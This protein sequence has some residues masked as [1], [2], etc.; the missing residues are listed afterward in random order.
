MEWLDGPYPATCPYCRQ[1]HAER[2]PPEEPPCG[3][4]RPKLA[5]ENEDAARIFQA[6]RG[7]VIAVGEQVIDLN[8]VAVKV[9]MDLYGI[10]RQTE[11]FEKVRRVFYHFESRRRGE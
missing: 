4:C 10:E 3:T 9:A 8:F 11:V 2:S 7:Q 5:E 6:V 1:K